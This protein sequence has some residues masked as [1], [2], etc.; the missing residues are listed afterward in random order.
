MPKLRKIKDFRVLLLGS[1][2]LL[3]AAMDT[4]CGSGCC[5]LSEPKRFAD[6]AASRSPTMFF[7]SSS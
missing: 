3:A 1:V 2:A 6:P 7:K 4:P 5:S